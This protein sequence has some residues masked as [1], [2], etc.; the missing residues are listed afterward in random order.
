VATVKHMFTAVNSAYIQ[1]HVT[2]V[3]S[4]YSQTHV[5]YSN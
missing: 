3:I 4:G 5:Y 2:A 1:T